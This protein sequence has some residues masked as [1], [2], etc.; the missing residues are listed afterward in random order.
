MNIYITVTN[1]KSTTTTQIGNK[2]I[3]IDI[4]IGKTIPKT[5]T[6]KGVQSLPHV[7]QI[8]LQMFAVARGQEGGKKVTVIK[9]K[10]K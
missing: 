4:A 7:I 9:T 1:T 6:I 3:G 2:K 10:S 8:P 5:K